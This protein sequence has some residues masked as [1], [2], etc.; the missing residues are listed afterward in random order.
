MGVYVDSE[1]L[2]SVEHD[3]LLFD[4]L[5]F[6]VVEDYLS[7]LLHAWAPLA[8][9]GQLERSIRILDLLTQIERDSNMAILQ[10]L[11]ELLLDHAEVMRVASRVDLFEPLS[12]PLDHLEGLAPVFDQSRDSVQVVHRDLVDLLRV[13]CAQDLVFEAH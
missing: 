7:R 5:A 2:A 12:H 9:V 1:V 13:V 6:F 10:E 8:F 11:E 4:G 3:V